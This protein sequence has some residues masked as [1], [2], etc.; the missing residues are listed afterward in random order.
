MQVSKTPTTP[1]SFAETKIVTYKLNKMFVPM[2]I[3]G[4]VLPKS[5]PAKEFDVNETTIVSTPLPFVLPG[6]GKE[7]EKKAGAK[8]SGPEIKVKGHRSKEVTDSVPSGDSSADYA[9]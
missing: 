9:S 3:Y 5:S 2:G 4:K 7:K 6:I 1:E 8:T